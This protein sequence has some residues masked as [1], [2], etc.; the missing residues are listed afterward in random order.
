LIIAGPPLFFVCV[1]YGVWYGVWYV[2]G[3]VYEV[4]MYVFTHLIF[5]LHTPL[6]TPPSLYLP[7]FQ[8]FSALAGGWSRRAAASLFQ[9]LLALHCEGRVSLSQPAPYGDIQV[10]AF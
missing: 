9:E 2:Y 1:W 4:C 5:A 7:P 8:T 6:L 10:R 3:S